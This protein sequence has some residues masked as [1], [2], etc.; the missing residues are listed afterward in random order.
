M[1][2]VKGRTPSGGA[3]AGASFEPK[4][5]DWPEEAS[6]RRSS[7]A[8][9]PQAAVL[10]MGCSCSAGRGMPLAVTGFDMK[11]KCR[12]APFGAPRSAR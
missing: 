2:G 1:N 6:N 12:H 4:R 3:S 10:L 7:P 8:A 11:A 5:L 9:A